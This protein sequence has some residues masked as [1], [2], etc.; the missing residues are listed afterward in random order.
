[1]TSPTLSTA[2][3]VDYINGRLVE[4]GRRRRIGATTLRTWA[5]DGTV[6]AWRNGNSW[7]FATA[8]LDKWLASESK[9][10]ERSAA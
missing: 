4:P 8:S 7:I 5:E 9:H 1:M 2:E 3:A 6:P 10:T